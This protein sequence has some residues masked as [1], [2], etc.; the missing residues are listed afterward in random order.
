M[1]AAGE[2]KACHIS[3]KREE[4]EKREEEN[5][6]EGK[7]PACCVKAGQVTRSTLLCCLSSVSA[8]LP[9]AEGKYVLSPASAR[10][11]RKEGE[12]AFSSTLSS[13]HISSID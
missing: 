8:C 5:E 1:P 7:A 4:E 6:E 9:Y 3:R 12:K 13:P 10:R 2:R 11:E